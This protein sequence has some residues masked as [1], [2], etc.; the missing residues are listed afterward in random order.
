[1]VPVSVSAQ[2]QVDEGGVGTAKTCVPVEIP[3]VHKE[4]FLCPHIPN[5]EFFGVFH[6]RLSVRWVEL[7]PEYRKDELSEIIVVNIVYEP[8]E[9]VFVFV[10][11]SAP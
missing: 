8:L 7:L 1:M 5:F 11:S 4:L 2:A 9:K 3:I 6:V 10:A